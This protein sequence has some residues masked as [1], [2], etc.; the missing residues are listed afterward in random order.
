MID[1]KIKNKPINIKVDIARRHSKSV[2][3]LKVQVIKRNRVLVI[4]LC[5]IKL[6]VSHKA[7]YICKII[8][9]ILSEYDINIKDAITYV[10]DNEK[11]MVNAGELIADVQLMKMKIMT[12]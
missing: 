4:N 8:Y 1:S 10:T 6:T 7:D 2:L 11:S 9:N 3:G 5:M 12:V